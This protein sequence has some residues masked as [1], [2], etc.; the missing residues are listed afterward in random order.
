MPA[1][2]SSTAPALLDL[3]GLAA[4]PA[5]LSYGPLDLTALS[6][7]AIDANG[8]KHSIRLEAETLR[9]LAAVLRQVEEC[10]PAALHGH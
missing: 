4:E 8:Q 7:Y 3:V 9:Q 6:F 2:D 10:F 1:E 5:T